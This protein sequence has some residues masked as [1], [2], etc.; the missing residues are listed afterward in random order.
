MNRLISEWQRLYAAGPD[1]AAID[2]SGQ[3]RALVLQVANPANWRAL[4]R[5]WQG[6]QADLALPAPGIAVNG[7]DGFQ[8]WFSLEQAVAAAPATAFLGALQARY[9]DDVPAEQV[10]LW[11]LSDEQAPLGWRPAPPLPSLDGQPVLPEQWSAFVAPD[12]APVFNETP[13]L[14]IPPN[15]EG[16]AD[17]LARLSSVSPAE[18]AAACAQLSPTSAKAVPEVSSAAPAPIG[19]HTDPHRFLLAVMN[20]EALAL[21]LRIEAAKALLPFTPRH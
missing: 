15:L 12:L 20:N 8:L 11:P 21:P 16:Q 7:R 19:P 5:V 9:L 18:W 14:D 17:Q 3:V 13:W 1:G 2:A 6:V 10:T 4:S